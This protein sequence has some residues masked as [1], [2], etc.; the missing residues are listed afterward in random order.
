MAPKPPAWL[1]SGWATTTVA[2]LLIMHIDKNDDDIILS[3]LQMSALV[4]RTFLN[5]VM[6]VPIITTGC[7]MQERLR[8]TKVLCRFTSPSSWGPNSPCGN[9]YYLTCRDSVCHSMEMCLPLHQLWV[10]VGLPTI[11]QHPLPGLRQDQAQHLTS[12]LS[13]WSRQGTETQPTNESPLIFYQDLGR[14]Q[15]LSFWGMRP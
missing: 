2:A 5:L 8:E 14:Q 4:A 15:S 12:D 7:E 9:P 6:T 11:E 1:S 3:C 13:D 10:L